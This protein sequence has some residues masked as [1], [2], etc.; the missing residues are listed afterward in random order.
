MEEN[1]P[2]ENT[3]IE[4]TEE[5]C[6]CN[7]ELTIKTIVNTSCGHTFCKDCF[8]SWLHETPTCALC[9][10]RFVKTQEEELTEKIKE[11]REECKEIEE[12][13]DLIISQIENEREK[14]KELYEKHIE[15]LKRTR[16]RMKSYKDAIKEL[17]LTYDYE[18][19]KL[20]K[21]QQDVIKVKVELVKF[22]KELEIIKSQTDAFEREKKRQQ[23]VKDEY[24]RQW[25]KLYGKSNQ[26]NKKQQ[27][28]RNQQYT[29][30]QQY[31]TSQ[32]YKK[33]EMINKKQETTNIKSKKSGIFKLNFKLR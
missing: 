1:T 19:D 32:R 13:K 18:D 23:H 2:I 9:R 6:I 28:T 20:I 3:L 27:Y 14:Y 24:L 8:F 10:T 16:E 33:Q 21:I 5:C 29:Q 12:Y 11:L 17:K 22:K 15:T 7:E 26:Y 30:N 31:L 4:D 25:N